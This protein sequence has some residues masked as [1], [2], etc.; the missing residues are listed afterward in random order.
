MITTQ[1]SVSFLLEL[2][3]MPH[4]LAGLSSISPI[5]NDLDDI[6]RGGLT[7]E[8]VRRISR[9]EEDVRKLKLR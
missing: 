6:K 5:Y 2:K 8:I 9:L 7:S 4:P 3:D 1:N